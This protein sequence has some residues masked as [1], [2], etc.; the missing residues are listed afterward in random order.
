[1]G[2][3]KD[4]STGSIIDGNWGKWSGKWEQQQQQQ[5]FTVII[6]STNRAPGEPLICRRERTT[7]ESRLWSER[8]WWRRWQQDVEQCR[9]W[10]KSRPAEWGSWG[11]GWPSAAFLPR[12]VSHAQKRTRGQAGWWLT[13]QCGPGR[14][15]CQPI[16]SRLGSTTRRIERE[17]RQC[18][19]RCPTYRRK[20]ASERWQW[21]QR[22]PQA[23]TP[24]AFGFVTQ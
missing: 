19:C 18:W 11:L 22:P 1:M 5:Q 20:P 15:R 2:S 6:G 4:F 8:G 16:R 24:I 21:R 3:G 9:H 10:S 17:Q 12:G 23:E 7:R 13:Q 14:P